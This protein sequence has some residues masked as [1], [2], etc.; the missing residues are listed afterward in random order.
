MNKYFSNNQ[1]IQFIEFLKS[2]SDF[3]ISPI[4]YSE[5]HSP[6]LL[7]QFGRGD[8]PVLMW[9][10]MHGNEPTTTYGVKYLLEWIAVNSLSSSEN[11]RDIQTIMSNIQVSIIFQL[12]PDGA[13]LYQRENFNGIDLNRDAQSLSQAESQILYQL[14]QQQAPALA[15]NLHDQRTVFAAGV[16]GYPAAISF[17]APA[18]DKQRNMTPARAIAMHYIVEMSNHLNQFVPERISRYSDSFNRHCFGDTFTKLGTPTILFEAGF[19][20][21]DY[22]RYTAAQL[23]YR[24]LKFLLKTASTSPPTSG[25]DDTEQYRLIPENKVEYADL[26]LK[27]VKV[28]INDEVRHY[29]KLYVLL[30][31]QMINQKIFFLPT[32]DQSDDFVYKKAHFTIDCS[33][34][35]PLESISN[36]NFIQILDADLSQF[37]QSHLTV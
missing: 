14:H 26:L 29:Q 17:L 12:N 30:K 22:Q 4:G 25:T 20:P 5:N 16:G 6:I 27:N 23:I 31:E 28:K 21:G 1:S 9:S 11:Y 3:K 36:Q 13:L 33:H 32:V 2:F 37:I 24:S 8:Y 18:A 19:V 34:R 35:N 15:C 7:I 10:Q